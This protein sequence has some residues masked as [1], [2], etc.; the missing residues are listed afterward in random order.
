[1]IEQREE[2]IKLAACQFDRSTR[3]V[4]KLARSRVQGPAGKAI[5]KAQFSR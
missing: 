3:V 5:Q 1:M 4:V 2:Q